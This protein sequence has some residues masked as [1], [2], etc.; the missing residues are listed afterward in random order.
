MNQEF[1]KDDKGNTQL[2]YAVEYGNYEETKFLL[3][4][5][6]DVNARNF[7]GRTPLHFMIQNCTRLDLAVLLLEYGA[8]IDVEDVYGNTALSLAA[9]FIHK[10]EYAWGNHKLLADFFVKKGADIDEFS[11][12]VLQKMDIIEAISKVNK[13]QNRGCMVD[14]ST[15]LHVAAERGNEEIITYLL[16]N[17]ANVYAIDSRGRYPY[18]LAANKKSTRKTNERGNALA[19][20]EKYVSKDDIIYWT[21]KGDKDEIKSLYRKNRDIIF[22]RDNGGNSLIHIAAEA[23]NLEVINLLLK[24]GLNIENCKN[25]SNET[26]L[27][28]ALKYYNYEVAEYLF[29]CGI[30]CDIF[31]AIKMGD[32]AILY[33]CLCRRKGIKEVNRYGRSP[34]QVAIELQDNVKNGYFWCGSRIGANAIKILEEYEG[35]MD[36]LSAT[37]LKKKDLIVQQIKK[38]ST[39]IDKKDNSN[40]IMH[41]AVNSGDLETIELLYHLGADINERNIMGR[42][43]IWNTVNI[44]KKYINKSCLD[45]FISKRVNAFDIDNWGFT[46]LNVIKRI[47]SN[48]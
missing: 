36:I 16:R 46:I 29:N 33:D 12:I 44:Q 40:S 45:W 23:G 7:E 14:G 28:K 32:D 25:K 24:L 37:R 22:Q 48:K 27:N 5:G 41:F 11:A 8:D 9:S 3:G 1:K 31:D 10:P 17:G 15:L 13:I 43:P 30:E 6:F 19:A 39:L 42:A 18:Y 21:L 4:K 20:F 26:A 35:E 47:E 38:D 2:H 34:L